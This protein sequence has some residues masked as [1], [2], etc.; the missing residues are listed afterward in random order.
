MPIGQ[1]T[2]QAEVPALTKTIMLDMSID[3]FAAQHEP[4]KAQLAAQYG[5]HLSLLTLE[6]SAGSLQL[7][8]TIATTNGTGSV[9][10]ETIQQSV[11]TIKDSALA[12]TIGAVMGTTVNVISLPAVVGTVR[13]TIPFACPR[14][15]WCTAG[16]VV[17]CPHNTYNP[18]KDQDYATACIPCPLDSGTRDL[19]S[20]G[21]EQCVCDQGFYDANASLAVDRDLINAMS[22]AGKIP[23]IE[24]S[25]VVECRICPVGTDCEIGSKLKTLPLSHGF[26][27]VSDDDTDV[28]R[29]PD[30]ETNCSTTFGTSICQSTSGCVGSTNVSE[31]CGPGLAGTFCRGCRQVDSGA[32]VFYVKADEGRQAHCEECNSG[33]LPQTMSIAAA[34]LAGLVGSRLALEKLKHR[35]KFLYFLATCSPHVKLKILVGFF[36]VA[37]KVD[38][39]YDVGLPNDVEAI[40]RTLANIFSLGLQGVATTPLACLGLSGYV[41]ELIF[42]IFLP[43]LIAIAV[44]AVIVLDGMLRKAKDN[45]TL[46]EK[47][48]PPV[49]QIMFLLYPLVTTTAFEGFPCYEFQSGRGWLIADVNIE[50]RTPDHT[51]ATSLSWLA[52]FLYPVGLL[53]LNILLLSRA[54]KAITSGNHTPLSRAIA[55]LYEEYDVKCFWW[56]VPEMARKLLLVGIFVTVEPGS[57]TQLAIGTIV[58]A[59]Y[60]IIQLTA[61]PYARATNGFLATASS[62][63]LLMIFI[64]CIFYKY[65]ALTD[66]EDI[67]D[68]MSIEQKQDYVNST[69]VI[70]IFFITSLVGVLFV[71]ALI[72]IV[73]GAIETRKY[74]ALPRLRNVKN[75]KLVEVPKLASPLAYH[76]FLSHSWAMGDDPMRITKLQLEQMMPDVKVF[77]DKDDLKKGAGAEYVD[78]SSAM[79]CFCTD[80]YLKSRPC[81]RELFRAVLRG[82]PLIAVFE[83]DGWRGGLS[84]V[85][86][87]SRLETAIYPPHKNPNAEPDRSWTEQ[88]ALD[89]EVDAWGF[90]A[91]PTGGQV[92]KALFAHEPIEWTRLTHFQRVTMRL[93]CERLLPEQ[94]HGATYVHGSL[95][96]KN[97]AAPLLTQ[98]RR[99][100]LYCSPHNAG[101]ERMTAELNNMITIRRQA[102]PLRVTQKLPELDQCEHMLVY[103][104]SATWTR[105]ATSVA[106]AI[107]VCE[108]LRK[109]VHLMPV[110]EFPSAVDTDGQRCACAFNEFWNEGWT[111]K[112]LLVGDANLYKEIVPALMPGEWRKAGLA[113]VMDIIGEGGGHRL[114]VDVDDVDDDACIELRGREQPARFMARNGGINWEEEMR[115]DAATSRPH[116]TERAVQLQEPPVPSAERTMPQTAL[117]AR[118]ASRKLQGLIGDQF[119]TQRAQQ[120]LEEH[121]AR[122]KRSV[123]A[124]RIEAFTT[125]G[126]EMPPQEEVAIEVAEVA[127]AQQEAREQ[128]DGSHESTTQRYLDR[129]RS[130]YPESSEEPFRA[131]FQSAFQQSTRQ[132]D[133]SLAVDERHV[134][135]THATQAAPSLA[136][137]MGLAVSTSPLKTGVPDA[138][139]GDGAPV[140]LETRENALEALS[141]RLSSPAR[142]LGLVPDE[143]RGELEVNMPLTVTSNPRGCPPLMQ[144]TSAERVEE[145][146]SLSHDLTA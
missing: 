32:L 127:P 100:H 109:G 12:S 20:T 77:L 118:R 95:E 97:I 56:E 75:R 3:D 30:A 61:Q 64:C 36:M 144:P 27:R 52:V 112:Q 136:R 116:E 74:L 54:S 44:L 126:A 58:C 92:S 123:A 46:I 10:V 101:A 135:S 78:V 115:V 34:V 9:D 4:L 141:T 23:I 99:F 110:H 106:F 89:E 53:V 143:A 104:T 72:V 140:V 120:Q 86:I 24:S 83:P 122:M 69:V 33:L 125:R 88:W 84:R 6:A 105:G 102:E 80:R 111:P 82:T 65:A 45:V 18:L 43:P 113:K 117:L 22:T 103:L 31:Q 13:V 93:I 1:S 28:R 146:V 41:Y 60:L 76:L 114:C 124:Q 91:T 138:A 132:Y 130:Q 129:V 137:G 87:E 66:T 15:H 55:F 133:V 145:G 5:V 68:K 16:L 39:V 7:R 134:E 14:G 108:A 119:S 96:S 81:A 38:T 50:C 121:D 131:H 11:A 107:E 49:L 19:N 67:Q 17:P 57:V 94:Y 21:R 26:Y 25:A 29:C 35:P 40:V 128:S 63:G 73:H 139:P 42:W 48:L 71:V 142:L 85:A 62:S 90:N 8:V 47:A 51:F 70:S 59:V 98:N 2:R 37:T 79:L